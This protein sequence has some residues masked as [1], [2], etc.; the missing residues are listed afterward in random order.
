M[1]KINIVGEDE[2]SLFLKEM[3]QKENIYTNLKEA[4]Y[5]YYSIPFRKYNNLE[6]IVNKKE[7]IIL[8]GASKSQK[9]YL[10]ANEIE[11]IDL[12]KNEKFV[13]GNAKLTAEAASLMCMLESKK[14]LENLNILVLGYGRIGKNLTEILKKMKSNVYCMARRKESIEKIISLKYN[15]VKFE[16]IYESLSNIDVVI[17]RMTM[18][19]FIALSILSLF[20]NEF[21]FKI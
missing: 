20:L 7:K 2:R 5:V 12:M 15:Y 4:D 19:I 16:N 8:G 21:N 10:D 11:Y 18:I 13:Y 14:S 3:L 6:E 9:E 17:I 1:Y